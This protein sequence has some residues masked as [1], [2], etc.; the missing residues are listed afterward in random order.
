MLTLKDLLH[1]MNLLN[2]VYHAGNITTNHVG[3]MNTII[4]TSEMVCVKEH[5]FLIKLSLTYLHFSDI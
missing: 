5:S 3:N 2:K 1:T 4:M